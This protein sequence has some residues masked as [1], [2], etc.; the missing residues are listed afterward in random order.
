MDVE[1]LRQEKQETPEMSLEL[2]K[3]LNTSCTEAVT[4]VSQVRLNDALYVEGIKSRVAGAKE[5]IGTDRVF[6]PK[7]DD[8]SRAVTETLE[9]FRSSIK[10][11]REVENTSGDL[12]LTVKDVKGEPVAK[13]ANALLDNLTSGAQAE[14]EQAD[15]LRK[16]I[17]GIFID[18]E[19]EAG[20][21]DNRE[22]SKN[23]VNIARNMSISALDLGRKNKSDNEQ[24]MVSLH[25]A[26]EQAQQ[27]LADY[28]K[29]VRS[30]AI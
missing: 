11:G 26:R 17:A 9:G 23:Y 14:S 28:I 30:E 3:A 7:Y 27:I 4:Q 24:A 20:A 16:R 21:A 22:H 8:F 18:F 10:P 25:K 12:L 6:G 19:A 2:T 13:K 29:E 5:Q 15:L 1:T